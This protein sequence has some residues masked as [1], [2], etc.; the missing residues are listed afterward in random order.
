MTQD[1]TYRTQLVASDIELV[2]Q[3]TRETGFF[4]AAEVEIA[5]ELCTLNVTQGEV[6]SGY[7]FLAQDAPDGIVAYACFGPIPGTET[8]FDLYWIVVSPA[9]QGRG[10]GRRLIDAVEKH[11]LQAGGKRL[12]AD[13]ASRAQ[14]A[15][16]RAFYDCCGFDQVAF[17]DDFY[18]DGD[19]K[20]IFVRKLA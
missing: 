8:S 7:Y 9:L 2:T 16:T 19:G 14:Y 11:V 13:T 4:S 6:S 1:T 12:Y 5:R 3:V 20:V 15:P 10:V 18:A 17:L